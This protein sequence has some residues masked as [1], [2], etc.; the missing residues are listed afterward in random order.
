MIDG[1]VALDEFLR[2]ESLKRASKWPDAVADLEKAI[3]LNPTDAN[4]Y[5]ARAG[6]FVQMGRIEDSLKDRTEAIRLNPTNPRGYIARGG[7]YHQLGRHKEGMEDRSEA[8]RL[9]PNLMEGWFARGSAYYLLGNFERS[10]SD[11]ERA[12][13]LNPNDSEVT[14][15]LGKAREKWAIA[16]MPV[17]PAGTT[18]VLAE[19]PK[20]ATPAAEIPDVIPKPLP[21]EIAPPQVPKPVAQVAVVVAVRGDPMSAEDHNQMGRKLSAASQFQLAIA[22]FDRAILLNPKHAQALNARGY[23][24]M[25]LK[26]YKNAL[27]D[28]TAAIVINPNYTNAF[29]NRAA[30]FRSLGQKEAADDDAEKVKALFG[31]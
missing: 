1:D 20:T 12:V 29:Q 13:L 14:A 7:S 17:A 24:R 8:I 10:V 9:D 21:V 25:R 22:A 15:I 27:N 16:R 28:F 18:V 26:D 30:A 31:K 2:A 23:A 6:A 11:L 4:L 3:A 19:A 5:M